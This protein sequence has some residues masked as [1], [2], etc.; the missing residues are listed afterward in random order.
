M[1]ATP[2][3]DFTE[4]FGHTSRT[5]RKEAGATYTPV[6]LASAMAHA[7]VSNFNPAENNL[8]TIL[9]P[10]CGDGTLTV[11]VLEALAPE[12]RKNI[13]VTCI[14]CDASALAM[15][16]ERLSAKFPETEFTFVASDFIQYAQDA[17]EAGQT[18]D[19]IIANPP[20]VRI[21]ALS[22]DVRSRIKSIYG[23]AGRTDMAFAFIM[24]FIHL[25]SSRGCAAVITS[26]RILSTDAGKPVRTAL[27]SQ[28]TITE[29]WDLGDT[30][31]FD[32]AVLPA[33]I[34][35]RTP[36]NGRAGADNASFTSIYETS[37]K[38]SEPVSYD[39]ICLD[40]DRSLVKK[41]P[42]GR[43]FEQRRGSLETDGTWR[44]SS[45]TDIEW[46]NRIARHTWKTFEDVGRISVGIK[47]TADKVFISKS[48][49]AP[50]PELLRPLI[51]HH[52]SGRYRPSG[53]PEREVLYPHKMHNGRKVAVDLSKFPNSSA[54][55]ERHRDRLEGRDYIAKSGRKW[56]EIWVPHS[57]DDWDAAKI[58]FRDIADRPTFWIESAGSVIN[59]DCY[60]IRLGDDTDPGLIWLMLAVGNSSL[61]ETFY[62]VTFNE[63]LYAG[64]RRFM[65]R[66]VK[67]FP[68]PDPNL[69]ASR[70]AALIA[71]QL[72]QNDID[73]IDRS[74]LEQEVDRLIEKAFGF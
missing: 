58:V 26:N 45:G 3:K 19:L 7:L 74:R 65:T 35:F 13:S 64:R 8:K 41:S 44:I 18:F 63:R 55:L 4:A 71:R 10:G 23:L 11:A 24:A 60:W 67:R 33:V 73:P 36:A 12:Y 6:R 31:L 37:K 70:N 57:P 9:D 22:E 29:L 21:Q 16:R 48:W 59:G 69:K 51:T 34:F 27:L 68:I 72:A 14:D 25:L 52:V 39:D 47:T 15:A 5:D 40:L 30:R 38:T 32:A 49:A 28:A 50:R 20:Y 46:A 53:T 43:I 54:Y 1:K 61:I 66:H 42:S 62:D 56:Y 17:K 2:A